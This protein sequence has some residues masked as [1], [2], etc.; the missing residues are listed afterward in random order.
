MKKIFFYSI[1]L[2]FVGVKAGE[3][4]MA[5]EMLALE[6]PML[7]TTDLEVIYSDNG[8]VMAQ[9]KAAKRLQYENGDTVYPKGFDGIFYDKD[10][11]IAGTLHANQAYQYVDTN[12]Y[13]LKG[14][15]EIKSYHKD[16]PKQL[17]TEELYWN[18]NNKE[19]YTDTFVRVES[20]EELLT[21]YGLVAKQD[22]SYYSILEPEGFA[23]VEPIGEQKD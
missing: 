23:Y 1:V 10:K 22:L 20:E 5:E 11:K 13:E 2:S 16:M 12:I 19:I 3:S 15:V 18:L 8:V 6:E 9:V 14:D 7:E 21:G 4:A 17:N